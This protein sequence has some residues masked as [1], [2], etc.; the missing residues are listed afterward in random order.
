MDKLSGAYCHDVL[1]SGCSLVWQCPCNGFNQEILSSLA[2]ASWR[3][4]PLSILAACLT[5]KLSFDVLFPW[6]LVKQ[7]H[8]WLRRAPL[9]LGN[10]AC[11]EERNRTRAFMYIQ[12]SSW[13]VAT[14]VTSVSK[15]LAPL[16]LQNLFPNLHL[17][18]SAW[19]PASF[20]SLCGRWFRWFLPSRP[21]S[22]DSNSKIVHL[23]AHQVVV[24]KVTGNL[25][26]CTNVMT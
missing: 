16:Y 3:C 14:P 5:E 19:P 6:L 9:H 15:P 10:H 12:Y 11:F 2:Q 26:Q 23:R 4:S 20:G 13:S 24:R 18:T 21:S 25:K 17:P 8:V 22:L 7:R 1:D